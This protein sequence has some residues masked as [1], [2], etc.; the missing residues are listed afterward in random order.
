MLVLN[1]RPGESI[2]IEPDMELT[3]LSVADRRVW[4]SLDAPGT[5]PSLRVSASAVTASEGRLEI[6]PVASIDFDG[7]DVR[8]TTGEEGHPAGAL[9]ATV[10]LH[11]LAGQRVRVGDDFYV[12]IA[13]LSKGNPCVAFGGPA[14]GDEVRVT[15]IR[16]A[17]NYVRL[18]VDAPERRVYRK[19]LWEVVQAGDQPPVPL[20]AGT[21][22]AEPAG[23]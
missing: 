14:I 1:R 12:G 18:G 5:V 15:L 7:D 10:A 17:G 16:P 23:G 20:L 19:E 22:G 9:Q 13:S 6:G 8:I 2:I 21:V 4:I 11:R 3:V